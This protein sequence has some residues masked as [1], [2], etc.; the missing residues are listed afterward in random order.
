M[1]VDGVHSGGDDTATLISE[2]RRL[3]TA[4]R[5]RVSIRGQPAETFPI[6]SLITVRNLVVVAR[7]VRAHVEVPEFGGR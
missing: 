1:A 2:T 4:N 7:T 6:S 3:A 5:S